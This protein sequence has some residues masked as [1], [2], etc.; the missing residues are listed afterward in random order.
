MTTKPELTVSAKQYFPELE[1]VID[2]ANTIASG[3]G[4]PDTLTDL[5]RKTA[6]LITTRTDTEIKTL[7]SDKD[8][9]NE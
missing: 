9:T 1:A 2:Q 7:F 3:E 8:R 6:D 5:M 4:C